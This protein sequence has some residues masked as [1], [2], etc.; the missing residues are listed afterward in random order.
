MSGH[1]PALTP[2]PEAMAFLELIRSGALPIQGFMTAA[3]A[4]SV[5]ERGVLPDG[6]PW[7]VPVVLPVP[8]SAAGAAS[9]LLTDPEGAPLAVLDATG[10]WRAEGRD[11]L[12]GTLRPQAAPRYGALRRLRS[13][14]AEIRTRRAEAG[15]AGGPLLAV[16][17]GRPLHHRALAQIRAAVRAA[18]A[19]ELLVLVDTP[20]DSEGAAPAVAAA[21]AALPVPAHLVVLTLPGGTA[22]AP[23]PAD[24]RDALAAHVAAAY[25]ADRLLVA[26]GPGEERP[27]VG[28]APIPVLRQPVWALDTGTG[29]WAPAAEIEPARRRAEPDDAATAAMLDRGEPLPEWFSPREVAAELARARPP[30]SRRGLTLF[31]TGLSG[32]GKSTVARGVAEQV[33]A[34]GRTVTLLDGDVVRRLLSAGLTFSRADRDLNIR[35]IGYVAAEVARHGGVAVCAPIAP[36]AAT[37][38]EVRAMAEATGD[39]FLVHVATPLEVCEERDRKGLYAKARAGEIPEFTGISDPYEAPEDAD[40][41]I[42]TTGVAESDSVAAV[43]A[44]LRADGRL[45]AAPRRDT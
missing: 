19:A 17:T 34:A 21:L 41:V 44:A 9:L 22:G 39:F 4:A 30:R 20:A 10:G 45:P 16:L 37:R 28:G 23:V 11:H 43:V 1:P 12:A 13:A 36:Y 31:F 18:G 7:P 25:G 29:A 3:E 33:G 38:A 24:R 14:P 35:R 15:T 8:E 40:L 42:D 5:R 2:G 26:A 27:P 32:S 6:T